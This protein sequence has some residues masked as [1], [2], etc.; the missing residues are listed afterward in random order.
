[1]KVELVSITKPCIEGVDS[2]E[3]L[4]AYCARVSNP[5]NQ[6]N[7]ATAPGLLRYLI[8][9]KHWSPFE[10]VNMCVSIETSR[11][12]A[13][14]I[15]RHRSFSFQEFSQRYSSVEDLE[16]FIELVELRMAA[17][18][19]R[20]SSEDVITSFDG[21]IDETIKHCITTYKNLLKAGVSTETARFV[22]PLT[23]K[24][25][26]YMNGSLRSWIHYLDLRCDK[27][28]QKEH[29]LIANQIKNIVKINFP[30]VYE[31]IYESND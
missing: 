6:M 17:E 29:R 18:T 30:A 4:V 21:I 10:M 15:L 11:A 22:L 12:I 5:G 9:N 13:Q 23:T 1:M 31:A 25:K 19:N 27:H 2:A 7:S 16:N 24:T 20:Q 28:T 26:L 8:K 3:D 14:Q